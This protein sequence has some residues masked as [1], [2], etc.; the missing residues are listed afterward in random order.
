VTIDR[1]QIG[2]ERPQIEHE[3]ARCG[4][5]DDTQKHPPA[6]FDANDSLASIYGIDSSNQLLEGLGAVRSPDSPETQL[7]F[8]AVY[9]GV[10]C[11]PF[12]WGE[13]LHLRRGLV[14]AALQVV[15]PPSR[16]SDV[17]S[18]REP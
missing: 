9:R 6:G 7:S 13:R 17:A 4:R 15:D 14:P 3:I 11:F 18:L 1:D 10:K 12:V 5:I 16:G 8:R 2:R